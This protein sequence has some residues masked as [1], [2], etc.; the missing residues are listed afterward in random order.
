MNGRI[1]TDL[2]DDAH[3]GIGVPDL[4]RKLY[5]A[6][7]GRCSL[8]GTPMLAEC[9]KGGR[10]NGGGYT[11]EHVVPTSKGGGRTGNILLAHASCN[12]KKGDRAP[13][14]EEIALLVAVYMR[15]AKIK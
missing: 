5:I 15:V 6:Q 11:E 8:C 3:H 13:T 9:A 14:A 1:I 4:V 2:K 10:V 7:E 12:H